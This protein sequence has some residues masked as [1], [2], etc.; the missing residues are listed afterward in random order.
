M[1]TVT[2]E[3]LNVLACTFAFQMAWTVGVVLRTIALDSLER[4]LKSI[5]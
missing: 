5:T 3:P 1:M 4:W 2:F